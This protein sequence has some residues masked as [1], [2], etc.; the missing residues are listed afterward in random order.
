LYYFKKEVINH[1]KKDVILINEITSKEFTSIVSNSSKLVL[2]ECYIENSPGAYLLELS[3]REIVDSRSNSVE[4]YKIDIEQEN[5]LVK[6]YNLYSF[7]TLLIFRN[8]S[9]L[10]TLVGPI[11][12][13]TLVSKVNVL[14]AGSEQ[15]E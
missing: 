4:A 11:P 5:L 9:L 10:D 2:I 7:P 15:L 12:N 6:Q 14:T 3:L 13:N 1:I 8:N